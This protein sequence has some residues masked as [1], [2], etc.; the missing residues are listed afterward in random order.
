MRIISEVPELKAQASPV[1][2]STEMTDGLLLNQYPGLLTDEV[3]ELVDPRHKLEEP[4]IKPAFGRAF[5]IRFNVS[6][7]GQP[8]AFVYT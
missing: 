3:N 7:E 5:K 6:A 8:V 2:L 1:E 4:L